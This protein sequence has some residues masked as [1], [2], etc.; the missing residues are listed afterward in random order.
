MTR[1]FILWDK[2][3]SVGNF[4]IDTQHQKFIS[5]INELYESFVD[6]T[7]ALILKK[8]I[9]ELI[10][11]SEYHFKTEEEL[12]EKYNYPD[13]EAHIAKHKEFTNKIKQFEEDIINGKANLTFQ[14]M[15]Y[16]RNWLLIH[17]RDEDQKYAG[18]F[19]AK[20]LKN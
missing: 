11:Y 14:L 4:T 13:K 18:F 8:I 2:T 17:L 3:Y 15:N 5:I 6:Q 1:I 9:K 16:L 19:K 12:F 20:D 7:T 10:E